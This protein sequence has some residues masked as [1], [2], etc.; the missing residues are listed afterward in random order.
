MEFGTIFRIER[1][2]NRIRVSGRVILQQA[3]AARA[4]ANHF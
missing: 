3:V 4:A 1:L 2:R